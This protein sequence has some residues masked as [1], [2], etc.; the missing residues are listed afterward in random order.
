MKKG[1]WAYQKQVVTQ[2]ASLDKAPSSLRM[3]QKVPFLNPDPLTWWSGPENIAQVRIDGESNWALLDSGSTI[4][5][6]TQSSSRFVLWTL[7][8]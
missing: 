7:V 6:V 1:G 8:P 3:S 2:P 5:D 4:N